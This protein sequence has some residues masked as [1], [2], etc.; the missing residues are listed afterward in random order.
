VSKLL[1]A[2]PQHHLLLYSNQLQ[3]FSLSIIFRRLQSQAHYTLAIAKRTRRDCLRAPAS[4]G[5]AE[6]VG[7]CHVQQPKAAANVGADI[8]CENIA[9][10]E[11]R[12]LADP[13]TGFERLGDEWTHEHFLLSYFA[14]QHLQ[15]DALEHVVPAIDHIFLHV[16][17][18]AAVDA[19]ALAVVL[20]ALQQRQ[21]QRE[22]DQV[23]QGLRVAL[24]FRLL[25]C[26]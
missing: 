15:R 3:V 7:S 17:S 12:H 11:Q 8:E 6:N 18:D 26:L 14:Q 19:Q 21:L 24:R 2:A 16:V 9:G 10:Q 4:R 13:D 5:R 23:V 25:G 20:N 22:H 1:P